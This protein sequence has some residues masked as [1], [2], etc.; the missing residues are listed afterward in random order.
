MSLSCGLREGQSE[1]LICVVNRYWI[2]VYENDED[3]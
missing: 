3:R 1:L 2:V